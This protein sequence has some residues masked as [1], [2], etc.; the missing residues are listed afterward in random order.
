MAHVYIEQVLRSFAIVCLDQKR[1]S[2]NLVMPESDRDYSDE[3]GEQ[4][5]YDKPLLTS[6]M[7][8]HTPMKKVRDLKI[9]I[10][11]SNGSPI[12]PSNGPSPSTSDHR[13]A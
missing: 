13:M 10:P 3:N 6:K 8:T 9:P 2:S 4:V 12:L 7:Q 1:K 11:D 5:L